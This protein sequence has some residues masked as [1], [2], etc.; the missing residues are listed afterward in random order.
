MDGKNVETKV[1]NIID[2]KYLYS[3]VISMYNCAHY[4]N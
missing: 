3:M 1:N 4:G 2:Y